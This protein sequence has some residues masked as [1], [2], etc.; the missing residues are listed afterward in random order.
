MAKAANRLP[1]PPISGHTAVRLLISSYFIALGTG[2]IGGTD[3]SVLL[4]PFLPATAAKIITG[5]AVALLACLVLVGIHRRAAALLLAIA[6]FWSS[7]LS[8][9][10]SSGHADIGGFWRDLA[11][12]GALIL[13]YADAGRGAAPAAGT[14][15]TLHRRVSGAST[16]APRISLTTPDRTVSKGTEQAERTEPYRKDFDL[17]RAS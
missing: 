17:V 5:A 11:L 10:S 3:L 4:V 12:I 8:L 16:K 13:T 6:L 1:T 2:A 7:Y 15:G 9:L 14:L